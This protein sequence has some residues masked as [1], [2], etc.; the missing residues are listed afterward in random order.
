MTRFPTSVPWWDVA[1]TPN[2]PDRGWSPQSFPVP[3]TVHGRNGGLAVIPPLQCL[4]HTEM[5]ASD[6]HVF[7]SCVM[8]F[9]NSCSTNFGDLTP[10]TLLETINLTFTALGE[11][12]GEVVQANSCSTCLHCLDYGL[13]K[14]CTHFQGRW[15]HSSQS[16]NIPSDNFILG[17]C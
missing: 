3:S 6:R 5:A 11:L 9:I 17:S 16:K 14:S 7:P 12:L 1:P 2:T 4:P 15:Y 8:D 13:F 10:Q